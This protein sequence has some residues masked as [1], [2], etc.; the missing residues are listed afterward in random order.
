MYAELSDEEIEN[1]RNVFEE[2]YR[3]CLTPE[4][5]SEMFGK[6]VDGYEINPLKQKKS[7][8]LF[9]KADIKFETGSEPR[10]WKLYQDTLFAS[11]SGG[12]IRDPFSEKIEHKYL[13]LLSSIGFV[14]SFD[15]HYD[16]EQAS[17]KAA[18]LIS[19]EF[20]EFNFL[21]LIL[22]YS[23]ELDGL[24][25]KA[26]P[27]SKGDSERLQSL[28]TILSNAFKLA[29]NVS[30]FN[31]ALIDAM[32]A[33]DGEKADFIQF[34]ESAEKF[35]TA[36]YYHTN[37][38][39]FINTIKTELFRN[40][41]S[42]AERWNATYS[43]ALST[44]IS[45]LVRDLITHPE[46]ESAHHVHLQ[47]ENILLRKLFSEKHLL[48]IEPWLG[49]SK[50]IEKKERTQSSSAAIEATHLVRTPN[51]MQMHELFAITDYSV[52]K[53]PAAFPY[54]N[55]MGFMPYSGTGDG[56]NKGQR[57]SLLD[58]AVAVD[59]SI[60]AGRLLETGLLPLKLL[61]PHHREQAVAATAY[62]LLLNTYNLVM[63]LKSDLISKQ[64]FREEFEKRIERFKEN[65]D[66][67]SSFGTFYESFKTMNTLVFEI[68]DNR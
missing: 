47:P 40:A 28:E 29:I 37:L 10:F 31:D 26:T 3:T 15:W 61:M 36:N 56:L 9:L 30:A 60:R 48:E 24:R 55:L 42:Q 44:D 25:K 57:E 5:L 17:G 51:E 63:N 62:H 13:Q 46:F 21:D 68:E 12:I 59:S 33:E 23:T 14:P 27:R 22:P 39:N 8:R 6:K 1:V 4:K 53:T 45:Q 11:K 65:Q 16:F 35:Q 52:K 66:Q 43:D 20:V 50:L 18:R 38:M 67:F 41:P 7:G 34:K 19:M 64:C 58:Y 54:S 49:I 2:N 32:S